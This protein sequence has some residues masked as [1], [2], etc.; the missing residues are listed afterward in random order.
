MPVVFQASSFS[1]ILILWLIKLLLLQL[2]DLEH[3]AA[4]TEQQDARLLSLGCWRPPH[5]CGHVQKVA[6]SRF[7]RLEGTMTRPNEG[8]NCA[9]LYYRW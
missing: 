5:I 7:N 3:H 9:H 8:E 6:G 2:C 1:S 4:I